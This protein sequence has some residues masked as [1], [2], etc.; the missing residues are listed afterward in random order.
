MR[1]LMNLL[2]SE[3]RAELL[4]F[5]K[6]KNLNN[7]KIILFF[8]NLVKTKNYSDSIEN[9]KKDDSTDF[10]NKTELKTYIE[11]YYKAIYKQGDNPST[12]TL[13]EDLQLSGF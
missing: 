2:E 12:N 11:N 3:L 1:E 8:M 9:L 10:I 13:L 4:H 7:E 6:F 5:K